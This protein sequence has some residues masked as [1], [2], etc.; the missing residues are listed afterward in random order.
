MKYFTM[1]SGNHFTAKNNLHRAWKEYCKR[2]DRRLIEGNEMLDNFIDR[3]K[4]DA[5]AISHKHPKCAPLKLNHFRYTHFEHLGETI[6]VEGVCSIAV[7][8]VNENDNEN[9]GAND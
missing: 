1:L 8:Q 4:H 2:Y 6:G 7:Y 9:G 5:Y 3:V